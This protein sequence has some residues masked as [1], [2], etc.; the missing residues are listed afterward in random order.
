[1]VRRRTRPAVAADRASG[2]QRGNQAAP[3][4]FLRNLGQ[5]SAISLGDLDASGGATDARNHT[6]V[7]V[8]EDRTT[9]H[10]NYTKARVGVIITSSELIFRV[11][12]VFRGSAFSE[13]QPRSDTPTLRESPREPTSVAHT[14][15]AVRSDKRLRIAMFG[16]VGIPERPRAACFNSVSRSGARVPA[17]GIDCCSLLE[18]TDLPQHTLSSQVEETCLNRRLADPVFPPRHAWS[19]GA[20]D[21]LVV[22]SRLTCRDP[23]R[24]IPEPREEA[25]VRRWLRFL[26]TA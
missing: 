3:R 13:F 22:V 17:C 8:S 24:P 18:H 9:K 23:L 11:V 7:D 12:R 14:E 4:T 20:F 15:C 19:A 2:S 6:S 26:G 1:M 5:R 10:T 21:W 25:F 16:C